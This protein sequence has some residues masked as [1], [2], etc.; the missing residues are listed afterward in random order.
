MIALTPKVLRSLVLVS[1]LSLVFSASSAT[2]TR[3]PNILILHTYRSTDVPFQSVASAFKTALARD[4]GKPLNFMEESLDSDTYRDK[5][6]QAALAEFLQ[7]QS[8]ANPI[9][10]VVPIG[11]PAA[12]FVI[13]NRKSAFSGTPVLFLSADR[14]FID[15]ASLGGNATL[16]RQDIRPASWVEDM[17]QIAPDTKNI[18]FVIGVSPLEKTWVE[19]MRRELQPYSTRLNLTFLTGMPLDQIEKQV[20]ALPPHS[21]IHFGLFI[22]DSAGIAYDGHEPLKRL[23]AAANAPIYGVFQSYMGTGIIGGRLNEDQSIGIQ[24]GRCATRIL[25]GES[26]GS[27]PPQI[28]PTPLPVY[29]WRELKRWGIDQSRLPPG[30]SILYRQPTFWEQYRW[31]IVGVIGFG[32]FETL[33]IIGLILNLLKGRRIEQSLRQS[34]ERYHSLFEAE[35]DALFLVDARTGRCLDANPGAARMYGY[36]HQELLDLFV[37]D[38]SAD[39]ENTL[40]AMTTGLQH[41]PLRWHL[42]KD[43]TR[44]PVEIS[45]GRIK[46]PDNLLDVVAMRDIS[47][48]IRAEELLRQSEQKYR[49]LFESMRD[50]YVSV[51][52]EGHLLEFNPAYREM[53]GYDEEELRKLTYVDITPEKWHKFENKII[54]D[55]VL[56]QGYSQVYEKEYRKKD[57]TVF[58]VVLRTFLLKDDNGEPIGMW[59]IVRDITERKQAEEALRERNRYIETVLEKAPIGFAVHGID[60]GKARF[61]STRFEEIYGVPRGTIDSHY[62]FFDK[63]WPYDPVLRERIRRRVVADMMSGDPS[64]MCWKNIPVPSATGE[65]R[66]ITALNIPMPEQNLMVS[67]VQDV[68]EG[69]RAEEALRASEERFRQVAETVSGFVWEVDADGLYTYLSPSVEKILGYTP[70]E[71]VG[72]MHFYDLFAP[73]AREALKH[74]ALK[75]FAACQRFYSF[76]NRNLSKSG[77][78]VHLETSGIPILDEAGRLLGYRGADTDVTERHRAETEAQIL[79]EELALFSR[80]ATVNELTASIAHEINQPL[81]AILSNSQAALRLMEHANPGLDEVRE[82]LKDIASDDQRAAEVIR[83]MRSML[84]KNTQQHMPLALNN[85]IT[86]ILP[87]VRND[88][89]ARNITIYLDLGAPLPRV[90]GDRVQLQQVILNLIV[91]AFEAME[92]SEKPRRLVLRTRQANGEIL[93]EVTDSGTGIPPHQLTSIFDPFFTTKTTGLGLGLPLS[94][95]IL[96]AHKGRLWAENNPERGATFHLALPFSN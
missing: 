26:A 78:A 40:L 58:P 47:E 8:A 29:D 16:I 86:D 72:K 90:T 1:L 36:S 39:P 30:S 54:Q 13:Q 60:D 69:V 87:L 9:D 64:R 88:A 79:R 46:N 59:A 51:D 23:H 57:G 45:S 76:P 49:R 55:Q 28:L 14:R 80:M 11:A 52:M 83:S 24:G 35:S 96:T 71:M 61:V 74:T 37:T 12:E 94:R 66:F 32:L 10:L 48:R 84:K 42:R 81:A 27:I 43:G 56:R 18:V 91:N 34:E 53:L 7:S 38:L 41:V 68:T 95:S 65:N 21:F 22:R 31:R 75:A 73:D 77:K 62:S 67:T 70:D 3:P 2:Q 92:A 6:T 25:R 5:T 89:R 82:I 17:L 93:L 15:T 4:F 63:V 85:L 19:I 33:L 50:A 20:S 44:F